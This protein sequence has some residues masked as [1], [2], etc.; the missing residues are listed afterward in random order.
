MPYFK[1]KSSEPNEMVSDSESVQSEVIST[2]RSNSK[3][4]DLSQFFSD[5]SFASLS[6]EQ[7]ATALA[8]QLSAFTKSSEIIYDPPSGNPGVS[9]S[10]TPGLENSSIQGGR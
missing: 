9:H 4:S 5:P 7:I 6:P 3:H 8:S 2:D 10:S 1:F